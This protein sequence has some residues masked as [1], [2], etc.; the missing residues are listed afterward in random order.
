MVVLPCVP[1]FL[2]WCCSMYYLTS[3][4]DVSLGRGRS[5]PHRILKNSRRVRYALVPGVLCV[6]TSD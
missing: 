6:P 5:S 2:S 1:E 3:N 4:C